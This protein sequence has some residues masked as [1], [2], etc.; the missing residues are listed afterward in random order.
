MG[1]GDRGGGGVREACQEE[2]LTAEA[3][4][5]SCGDQG[6]VGCTASPAE[7]VAALARH[8]RPVETEE[9]P[10][11]RAFGRV[12]AQGIVTD[13]QSPAADVSA[14]DGFAV[15]VEDTARGELP[16]A[17]EARAGRSTGSLRSGHAMPIST[18]APIPAGADAVVK[19]EDATVVDGRVAFSG[20]ISVGQNI[21]RAGEN[22]PAGAPV[23]AAGAIITPALAGAMASFG[24]GSVRVYRRVRV[25]VVVTGDEVVG[26]REAPAPWQLRDSNGLTLAAML[27][28]APWVEAVVLPRIG[29]DAS[30]TRRAIQD[31]ASV[32]DLVLL[33][34]GVSMGDHDH[35]PSVLRGAGADIIFHRVAQRP[36]RPVL[37][38]VLASG[39]PVLGLP[40]NPV[41]VMVTG[42]RM[43][44]AIAA[45]LAGA[46]HDEHVPRVQV[47]GHERALDLWWH[48]LV[49]VTMDGGAQIAD[50]RGS[51]DVVA[52][53]TG[54]GFVEIPPGQAGAGPWAFYSWAW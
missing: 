26:D 45:R 38:A 8:A 5:G 2:A 31:A 1:G 32:A 4:V 20:R 28:S 27:A 53:A 24:V 6:D 14:M 54:D 23:S 44:R 52:A 11:T 51:G 16:L 25:G 50:G 40:G 34:G 29:D 15:R 13:R 7:A 19:K 41:S 36:G 46:A 9:L 22:G 21:R 43:A 3:N 42:R 37:G 48:R 30:A 33:T 12:L 10:R 47:R 18:G 35:V 17:G 49:R 39:V